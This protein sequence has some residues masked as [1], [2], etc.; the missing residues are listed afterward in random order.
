VGGHLAR[1]LSIGGAVEACAGQLGEQHP[2]CVKLENLHQD[3]FA[4]LLCPD[5]ASRAV[6]C[7][8]TQRNAAACREPIKDLHA[9]FEPAFDKFVGSFGQHS[10]FGQV[11]QACGPDTQRLQECMGGQPAGSHECDGLIKEVDLCVG[12]VTCPQEGSSLRACLASGGDCTVER[13]SF[14][15]CVSAGK[16]R[17]WQDLGIPIQ[18]W[19]RK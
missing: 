17:M 18:Q 11:E 14:D 4:K 2:E 19:A 3:C 8:R 5:Q 6:T 7:L 10:L 13:A 16:L 9:C 15:K 12:T 1:C